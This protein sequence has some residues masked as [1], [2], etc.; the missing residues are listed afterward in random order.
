MAMTSGIRVGIGGWSYEPWRGSFYPPGLAHTDE[1]AHAS[2]R[3]SAIEINSTYHGTQRRASFA[4]W[5]DTVPDGFVFS[6]KASRYATQR[7]V[8]AE[9][10]ESIDR[11]IGSGIAELGPK[12]GPIVW[13]LPPTHAYDEDD[14]AAFLQLLP[15]SA[16]GVA[17]RHAIEARHASHAVP[18]FVALARR[19]GVAIVFGDAERFPSIGDVTADFVYAR[20]MRSQAELEHGYATA[21][22]DVIATTAREWAQ[23]LQPGNVP[24]VGGEAAVPAQPRDVYVFFINGAKEKAPAAALALRERLG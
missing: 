8:L 5:R 15:R 7:R 9:A 13:Q 12:L 17:L 14:M 11:F 22:L 6:V 2:R 3:L 23:G 18:E 1:L 19:H 10:G 24:R 21:A 16:E 4:K 20:L